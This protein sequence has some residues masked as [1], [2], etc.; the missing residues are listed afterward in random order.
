MTTVFRLL[1][2]ED[3]AQDADLTREQFAQEANDFSIEVV[4]SGAA[5]RERLSMEPFDLLLLD[6]HLPDMDGLDLLTSLRTEG[7]HL[8][9][10]MVTGVGDDETV[11][12]A[13]RAGASD[14]VR[15]DGDYLQGLPALLRSTLLEHG[16]RSF[17]V[18]DLALRDQ[19]VLYIE[20]NEMDAELTERHFATYAPRLKLRL[21]NSC[22]DALV[23]LNRPHD[24]D[25][26]LTD[27]RVPG[28]DALEFIHEAK[29]FQIELPFI[30]ITGKGDEAT[31]V[32]LLRLGATDYLV[33]RDNYLVQLPH[34]IEHALH[35]FRL[36]QTS[37]RLHAELLERTAELEAANQ[38][39]TRAKL[40]AE[41][42]SVIKSSFLANVSHEIRT[43]LNAI[44][45]M[46]HLLRRGGVTPE[47]AERLKKMEAAGRHLLD[48][49]NAVLDLSKI[50]AGKFT[51]E[52]S[53]V[54]VGNIAANVASMLFEKAQA[55]NI[56][57]QVKTVT[58]SYHLLGD[59]TR[60]QQALLNFAS[61]AIKFT[62]SGSVILRATT[63]DEHE[64]SI[65]VRFEVQDTGIGIAPDVIEKLFASF[66]QADNSTTRKYGGTGLGLA[67]TKKLA[68]LMGGDAGVVSTPGVGSTFWFTARLKKGER[69]SR[70]QDA[71]QQAS[72]EAVLKRDFHGLQVLLVED[73]PI[74]CEVMLELLGN[75]G[76][77]V[78]SAKDGIEAVDA[79]RAKEYA[80]ILMDMQMPRM[81]GLEATREIRKL[82]DRESLPILA[83]TAN[84]FTEDR[85]RC[86]DAGMND[87]IAKPV[88][89]HTLFAKLVK[90]LALS[91]R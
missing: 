5:C 47:Q 19:Q 83:M 44:T 71:T 80:L 77:I 68:Q 63:Q 11:A 54:N 46:V 32:A 67:I 21:I 40:L 29:R 78:D 39:L 10:V 8:P 50:E 31:A 30:V 87:F 22:Q 62:D 81:N 59:P 86:L 7:N 17:L 51:L 12:R 9:V 84:A 45:G 89:P 42:A 57:L 61:N 75:T 20:P 23:L 6:N 64:G 4:D 28:M 27:L 38:M 70:K 3:N 37:R 25:L 34:A 18:N 1:Y 55:K 15:K 58:D 82:P 53:D 43:P 41:S 85:E 26:V 49:I 2:A 48:I 52:E 14:Y 66:E 91:V 88:D 60:L 74:N 73:E 65:L 24:I 35:R 79:V 13:L 56:N 69:P 36:D 16:K 72:A 76:L 90:W 33:K